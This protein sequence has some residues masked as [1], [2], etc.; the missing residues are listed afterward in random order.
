MLLESSIFTYFV[1]TIVSFFMQLML[2]KC[3]NFDKS[4]KHHEL[5]EILE[6]IFSTN[7]QDR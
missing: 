7:L 3:I 6:N 2:G 1:F 5:S 4:I